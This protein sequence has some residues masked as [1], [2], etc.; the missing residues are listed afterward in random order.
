MLKRPNEDGAP[1]WQESAAPSIA[2]LYDQ[3][4]SLSRMGVNA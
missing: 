1:H 2:D 4:E 3:P